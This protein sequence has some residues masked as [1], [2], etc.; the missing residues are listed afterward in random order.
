MNEEELSRIIEILKDLPYS[1][2]SA[3]YSI[4]E[5]EEVVNKAIELMRYKPVILQEH[6]AEP[7]RLNAVLDTKTMEVYVKA[8]LTGFTI[9]EVIADGDSN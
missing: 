4:A 3:A 9:E 7:R 2:K 8:A 5:K 6:D 1:K